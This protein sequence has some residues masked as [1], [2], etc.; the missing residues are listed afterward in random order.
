MGLQLKGDPEEIDKILKSSENVYYFDDAGIDDT[1]VVSLYSRARHVKDE[2]EFQYET[3]FTRE[4]EVVSGM[5]TS[6][7]YVGICIAVYALYIIVEMLFFR[8]PELITTWKSILAVIHVILMFFVFLVTVCILL[9]CSINFLKQCYMYFLYTGKAKKW[10]DARDK[11]HTININDER[12]FLKR[13]LSDYERLFGEFEKID[14]SR[15][16]LFHTKEEQLQ[17]NELVKSINKNTIDEMHR[18]INHIDYKA[19]NYVDK[20]D[21]SGWWALLNAAIVLAIAFYSLASGMS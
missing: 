2:Y 8:A 9:P 5:K 17:V 16:A 4:K 10:D 11:Y 14:K 3:T 21:I 1:E 13:K 7:I 19:P 18:F 15:T 12:E 6:A 20:R